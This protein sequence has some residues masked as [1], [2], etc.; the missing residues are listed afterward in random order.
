MAVCDPQNCPTGIQLTGIKKSLDDTSRLYV[1]T[2]DSMTE[3]ITT[4]KLTAEA[5]SKR[6]ASVDKD[7]D[8]LF[9]IARRTDEKIAKERTVTDDKIGAVK[10]EV[11]KK[12]EIGTLIKGAT[13]VSIIF[14]MIIGILRL[15]GVV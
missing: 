7:M 3:V 5:S 14:G 12:I 11:A 6:E 13:L 8:A 2:H 15:A 1:K 10:A 4:M 9:S